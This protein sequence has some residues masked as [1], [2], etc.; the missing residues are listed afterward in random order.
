MNLLPNKGL[1]GFLEVVDAQ[2]EVKKIGKS[3][4]LKY[5]PFKIVHQLQIF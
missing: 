2:L 1:V 5:F 4:I 3:E